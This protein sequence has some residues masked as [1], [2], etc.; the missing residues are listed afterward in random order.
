MVAAVGKEIDRGHGKSKRRKHR[1]HYRGRGH[2]YRRPAS[3]RKDGRRW[4]CHVVGTRGIMLLTAV[5]TVRAVGIRGWKKVH[6]EC[7]WTRGCLTFSRGGVH[8]LSS[9]TDRPPR[10]C[11]SDLWRRSA[12]KKSRVHDDATAVVGR[13]GDGGGV[14]GGLRSS[15]GIA[16]CR[17]VGKFYLDGS[18]DRIAVDGRIHR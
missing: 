13:E 3:T 18:G 12:I 8:R 14:D 6:P 2:C 11:R 5:Q 15:A 10:H 7:C 4:T 16:R 17:A 9:G 1:L